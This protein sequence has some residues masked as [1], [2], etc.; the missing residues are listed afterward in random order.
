[1]GGRIAV[2]IMPVPGIGWFCYAKD[3]DGNTFGMMQ[4]DAA[5]A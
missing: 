4:N 3:P 2:R 1:L 5:T